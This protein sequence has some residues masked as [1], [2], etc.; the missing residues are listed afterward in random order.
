MEFFLEAGLKGL[1][2]WLRFFGYKT[3]VCEN[4][5]DKEIILKHKDKIF[6]ITSPSTAKLLEKAGIKYLLLPRES[7]KAQLT[8]LV[9]KLNLNTELKLNLCSICG[10]ELISVKKEDFKEL[11]PLKVYQFYNEFNYCPKC[12]KLYWE[13]DHIKRL[14]ERLKN[15]IKD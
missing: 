3:Q 4:K 2:K 7:L 6:L 14:K 11:I 9:H 8:V 12:K 15:L 10:E 1:N 13:G 5:I